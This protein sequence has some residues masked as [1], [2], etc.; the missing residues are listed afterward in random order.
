[1][2]LLRQ[3]YRNRKVLFG[4]FSVLI[5][6]AIAFLAPYVAPRDPMETNYL[7]IYQPPSFEF[8]FGTDDFG[9][10]LLS[11]VIFGLRVSA[12]VGLVVTTITGVFGALFGILSGFYSKLDGI[13]MR[14]MDTLMS[15]PTILLAI[16][17]V[18]FLGPSEFN[19]MIA[20]SIVFTPR[21]ARLIRSRV[22]QIVN[23]N[24][25]EAAKAVGASDLRILFKHI[26]KNCL[27]PLL[28]QQSFI[29]A[30][31]II[32]EAGLSFVGA[33]TPPPKPSLGNI[34]SGG[35]G[36]MRAAPWITTIPG[37]IILIFVIS[38]NLVGD[39]LRDI[40][41]PQNKQIQ[42]GAQ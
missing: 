5:I 37:V 7:K 30:Y 36:A 27:S 10:D 3:F 19:A 21:T 1:M 34:M 38:V 26:L 2:K 39:G 11:R 22:L 35:R 6:A 14:I 15:I 28:V 41:E 42:P 24:Y 33:G 31:A 29:F 9:R 17:I 4:G 20:I 23:R 32:L 40:L 16:A 8:P 13:I 18:A 12:R 25:I